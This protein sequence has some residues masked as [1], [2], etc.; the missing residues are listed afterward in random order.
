MKKRFVMTTT[1]LMGIGALGTSMYAQNVSE[2]KDS[3]ALQEVVVKAARIVNKA[4]G[5]LIFPSDV[6]KQNSHSGFSLL[7][8]LALPNIRVDEVGRSISAVDHKGEVQVR[9]N[10]II[11]NMH[12]VQTL[13]VA[14]ISHVDY[15]N[16]PGVRYG[17]DI[18]YVI[19]IRTRRATTGGTLGIDLSN[20]LTTK[21]GKND[22]Y[23][24]V[25]RGKSQFYLF[26]EQAYA[27]NKGSEYHEDAQYH[28]NDGS[29]YDISR[30]TQNGATRYYD[31]TL[32]LKYNLADS[33]SYVFQASLSAD[34]RNQPRT[35]YEML[36]SE[37][38][39]NSPLQP[40]ALDGSPSETIVHHRNKSRDFTPVLDLYFFHQLGKHQSLTADVLG[41]YIR[42]KGDYYEDEG[43]PY[44]YQVEGKTYSMISEAIYENRLKPFTLSAGFHM[45]W[46]YM[47][48]H[49]L[50]DVA[51]ENGIHSSGTYGFAQIKGS[52]FRGKDDAATLSYVAGF[53]LSNQTYRQ[54]DEHYSFWLTRPKV[55]LVYQISSAFQL[56]Y[57]FELSQHISE[58]AMVSDTRI[59][60]NSMEWTVGNPS[61]KPD[62]RY[63]HT[64]T[65][66]YN[67]TRISNDLSVDYRT[68]RHC[69]LAKYTRT[70]DNQF[71][72]TQANQPHC[73]LL[74]VMDYARFDIIPDH[75]SLTVNASIN[76]FFNKGDEYS[77]FYTGY[78]Y[79]GTLQGYWGRWS[80]TL[81]GDSGWN[82]ME[83]ENIG[84]NAPALQTSAS[85]HLGNFDFTLTTQNLFMAHPKDYSAEIVNALVQKQA[86]GR[87]SSIGNFVMLGVAWNINR[88]KEYRQIQKTI[89]N[90]ERETGILK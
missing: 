21:Y 90:R 10:G 29:E 49:Y 6:Q 5:K 65:L 48:N 50:G 67:R 76:R 87:N 36:F 18:A 38:L 84:H 55:S 68:N 79:G 28:L 43:E 56:R 15:I 1:M 32:Q 77:H 19:D 89:S 24:S 25:N 12:D 52:L 13:D 69:S 44:Q 63:E 57:D 71:L 33:A 37:S 70:E 11:A 45:D 17:K 27:N 64:L 41:T 9:I 80:F 60:K 26:Y 74:Y 51:S 75:L 14:S 61:L 30:R 47:D 72:N 8:K 53:G 66:S 4:D 34:F 78:N 7:S 88:G 82:F 31:N 54:G 35:A 40:S 2:A 73:N 39:K 86:C 20:A 85:Y 62:S 81:Y 83:A 58:I 59:R 16:S 46:K 22:V 3:V 23:G 42:T